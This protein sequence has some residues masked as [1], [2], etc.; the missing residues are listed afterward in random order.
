MSQSVPPPNQ[1]YGGQPQGGNPFAGQQPGAPF[2]APTPFPPAPPARGNNFGLGLVAAVGA[3]LVGAIVYGLIL[4]NFEHQIGYLAVGVGFLVGFCA[5]KS[6]GANP[7]MTV[8]SALLSVGA[9]YLGQLLGIAVVFSDMVDQ[10]VTSVFFDHFDVLTKA[11]NEGAD[12]KTYLFLA[13]GALGA[14]GG[15]RKG[16]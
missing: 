2:G 15:A 11:W 14:V 13:L 1:P 7:V 10:S 5:R 4:G 3:G 6:G 16:S 9:V 12:G 8:V